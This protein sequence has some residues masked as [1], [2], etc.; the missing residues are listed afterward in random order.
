MNVNI[1]LINHYHSHITE[2]NDQRKRAHEYCIFNADQILPYA[3]L[4]LKC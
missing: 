1:N 2:Y 4:H 3:L